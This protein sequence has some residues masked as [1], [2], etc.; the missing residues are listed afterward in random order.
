[1]SNPEA[2]LLFSVL[3]LNINLS[4][5]RPIC[6][7]CSFVFDHEVSI[8]DANV[9]QSSSTD[10]VS[11]LRWNKA[12]LKLYRDVTEYTIYYLFAVNC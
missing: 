5:H 3:D 8:D 1:M 10:Y 12:D 11:Q 4:D 9:V 7:M 2:V 6:V